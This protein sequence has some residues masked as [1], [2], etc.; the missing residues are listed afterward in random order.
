MD[1]PAHA[2]ATPTP[3][4][5]RARPCATARGAARRAP[6]ARLTRS[7]P[8]GPADRPRRSTPA[9]I[10]GSAVWTVV[11]G[12]IAQLGGEHDVAGLER[13]V[14]RAA[15]AGDAARRGHGRRAAA[16][17]AARRGPIPI[18]STCAHGAPARTARASTDIGAS[19]STGSLSR[20][21]AG[22]ASTLMRRLAPRRR[23]HRLRGRA[24]V[25]ASATG[26]AA[27]PLRT[28]PSI[29][30]GQPVSVWAPASA[31]PGSAVAARGTK[32]PL[33]GAGAER[34]RVVAGDERAQHLGAAFADRQQRGERRQVALEHRLVG[35]RELGVGGGQRDDE[36]LA[37]LDSRALGAV[38]DPLD[39]GAHPGGELHVEHGAVVDHVDVDDRRCAER[40]QRLRRDAGALG[41]QAGHPL[42]PDRQHDRV[43]GRA[44]R[45]ACPSRTGTVKPGSIAA[46][47]ARSRTS[48]PARRRAAPAATIVDL[49]QR[50]PGVPEVARRGAGEQPLLEDVR[51]LRE[52]GVRGA[53]V[54][55]RAGDQVPQRLHGA[56]ALAVSGQPLA[57]RARRRWPGPRRRRAPTPTSPPPP[58]AAPSTRGTGSAAAPPRGAAARAA[59]C[60]S[61]GPGADRP[62]W[63][64]STVMSSRS[65]RVTIPAA[66]TRSTNARYSV[67]QRRKTCW[68]LSAVSPSRSNE[69]ACPPS[70][71]R[72]SSSVTAW[73]AAAQSSAA[74]MPASPPP[75]TITL[76]SPAHRAST[77][78]EVARLR[79]ATH[80]FSHGASETRVRITCPGSA[81]I[82]SRISR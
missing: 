22:A 27:C 31:S 65:W 45:D 20:E 3:C 29:V 37:A 55:G 52:R 56:R 21:S 62:P 14:Q 7:A 13:L 63:R 53:E 39:R 26:A 9:R 51:G 38:E 6:A 19:T 16:E 33:P 81:T 35:H 36:V 2:R 8:R 69:Y 79:A 67:Q 46:T 23:D 1:R 58:T 40:A 72:D 43:A 32:R 30:A 74:V 60:G 11:S 48:T 41:D 12:R 49:R 50:N 64:P 73:P 59:R 70:R 71:P 77:P 57:E 24:A 75:T 28:A 68:P 66:P 15:E 80:A 47:P 10:V 5:R 61:D 18:R 34:R 54:D 82:R 44:P 17:R 76:R 25:R 78:V 4:R 42:R